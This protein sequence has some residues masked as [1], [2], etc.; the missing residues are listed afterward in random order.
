MFVFSK[1]RR[2]SRST[3]WAL[4]PL[5]ELPWPEGWV[6]CQVVRWDAGSAKAVEEHLTSTWL[7]QWA[8]GGIL[9]L[10]CGGEAVTE[11]TGSQHWHLRGRQGWAA[12]SHTVASSAASTSR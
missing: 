9:V 12:S 2:G 5:S 1:A 7:R 3:V 8:Q 11:G 4:R 10:P 6:L